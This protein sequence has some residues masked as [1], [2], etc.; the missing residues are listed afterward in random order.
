MNEK[1][2]KYLKKEILEDLRNKLF[3]AKKTSPHLLDA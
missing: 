3:N 1:E 2:R